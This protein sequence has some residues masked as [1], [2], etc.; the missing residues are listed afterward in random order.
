MI[1]WLEY[2]KKPTMAWRFVLNNHTTNRA[3][4]TE[5]VGGRNVG[6]P[7]IPSI[8]KCHKKTKDAEG[9]WTITMDFPNSFAPQDGIIMLHCYRSADQETEVVAM[10]QACKEVFAHL[11]LRKP[12]EVSIRKIMVVG[13][14]RAPPPGNQGLA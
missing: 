2:Q 6:G 3:K 8:E 7:I 10:G 5:T 4:A 14:R 11:L 13:V 1:E 9:R 12:F